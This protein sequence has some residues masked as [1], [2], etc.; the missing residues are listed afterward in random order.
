MD[1]QVK[2]AVVWNQDRGFLPAESVISFYRGDKPALTAKDGF[3]ISYMGSKAKDGK[4]REKMAVEVVK[5]DSDNFT[6]KSQH[7]FLNG[8]LADYQDTLV[9]RAHSGDCGMEV[10]NDADKMVADYFDT[11]RD[12]SG[13][14]ITKEKIAEYVT[15]ADSTIAA[16]IT[17]RALTKNAQMKEET[18][19]SVLKQWGEMF[20]RMTKFDLRAIYTPAQASL[21]RQLLDA[22]EYSEGDEMREWI[23]VKF[24][25]IEAAMKEDEQICDAI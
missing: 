4:Q 1:T 24:G 2:N 18:L 13:R 8:L 7:E 12:S 11:S 22:A 10:V 14:K 21:I 17:A 3:R 25:K 19:A 16:V 5:H 15:A 20:G 23:N 9:S 6:S